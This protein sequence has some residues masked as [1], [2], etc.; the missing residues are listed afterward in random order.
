MSMRR[1][2]EPVTFTVPVPTEHELVLVPAGKRPAGA[3]EVTPK[4][5]KEMGYMHFSDAWPRY[6]HLFGRA[7]ADIEQDTRPG[8]NTIR[9]VLCEYLTQYEHDPDQSDFERLK[10][11]LHGA[12]LVLD[13]LD[14]VDPD[15]RLA[16]LVITRKFGNP[17]S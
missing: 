17:E 4:V 11:A 1:P 6:R 9:Y 8:V 13:F 14:N 7:G 12:D 16:E 5:L 15:A 10:A 3:K 2:H